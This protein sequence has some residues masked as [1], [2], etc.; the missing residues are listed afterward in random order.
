MFGCLF[1]AVINFV[2]VQ[3]LFLPGLPV[4]QSLL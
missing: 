2:I 3:A 4:G 1:A